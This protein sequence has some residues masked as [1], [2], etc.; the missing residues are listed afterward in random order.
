MYRIPAGETFSFLRGRSLDQLCFGRHQ[1]IMRFDEGLYVSVEGQLGVQPADSE[2][3]VVDDT[4]D[5]AATLVTALGTLVRDVVV[6]DDRSFSM[7]FEGG[8]RVRVIDSSDEYESFQ[9]GH[10]RSVFIV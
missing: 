7:T 2:E 4:R 8:L 3:T 6:D 9:I 10:G 1:L 5:A